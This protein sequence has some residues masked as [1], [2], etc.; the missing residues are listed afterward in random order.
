M[1]GL[2]RDDERLENG[3]IHAD[4]AQS[5]QLQYYLGSPDPPDHDVP[6]DS[7]LLAE[8]TLLVKVYR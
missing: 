1:L 8:I 6:L 7:V 3:H 4:P 5:H 2:A